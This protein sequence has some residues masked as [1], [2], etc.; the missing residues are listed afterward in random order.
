M[1]DLMHS[2]TL[3]KVGRY[4]KIFLV[5]VDISGRDND[6]KQS[7]DNNYRGFGFVQVG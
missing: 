1:G 5:C 4:V 7:T 3:M 2:S 6:L